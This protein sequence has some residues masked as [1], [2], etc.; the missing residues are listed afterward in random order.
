MIGVLFIT[1][2]ILLLLGIPIAFV[3]AGSSLLALLIDGSL[4]MAI[5]TQR[6][7]SGCS[8]FTLLAIPFFVL[9]GN[10]MSAGGMSRRLINF[11]DVFLGHIHGGLAMVAVA[12]CAFFAAL[13]GSSAATAAAI[14]AII[15]PEM[16][17]HN[18]DKNFAA[19][20]V[21]SSA[22]LGVIIA[23]PSSKSFTLLI[24]VT[25]PKISRSPTVI[26]GLTWSKMVGP[27]K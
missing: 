15:I 11:C 4:N 2:V 27:T 7:F 22:E 19:A 3:L 25:G 16:L 6:I 20:T 18:Y 13:S 12:A 1:F 24:T 17:Q 14:G 8:G 21:A 23:S 26:P 5:I 9:A 10:L